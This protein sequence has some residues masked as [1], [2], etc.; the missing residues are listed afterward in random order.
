MISFQLIARIE[1][2]QT[3]NIPAMKAIWN[4]LIFKAEA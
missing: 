1:I 4:L 2:K 3:A